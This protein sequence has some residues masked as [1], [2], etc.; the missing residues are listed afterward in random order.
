MALA[1]ERRAIADGMAASRA[2]TGADERRAIGQRLVNERRGIKDDLNALETTPRKRAQLPRLERRGGVPAS[3]GVGS[4]VPPAATGGGLSG[5]LEEV[6]RTY[7]PQRVVW[8]AD[9][10]VPFLIQRVNEVT[11][12]DETGAQV[13][14]SFADV[15]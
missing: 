8:S 4:W 13:P 6:S 10:L 14:W 2:A 1:D 5:P 9:G 3:M 11:M 7:H 12:Q 15:P